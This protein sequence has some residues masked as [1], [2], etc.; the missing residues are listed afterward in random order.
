M[1]DAM[2][3]DARSF[4]T[5]M[6][7]PFVLTTETDSPRSIASVTEEER[8]DLK[9]FS[10]HVPQNPHP[11]SKRARTRASPVNHESVKMMYLRSVLS[12]RSHRTLT[13]PPVVFR[14]WSPRSPAPM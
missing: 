14:S 10:W 3:T 5:E 7:M 11:F 9:R 12:S 2:F 4:H 8:F 1:V 13:T 6:T